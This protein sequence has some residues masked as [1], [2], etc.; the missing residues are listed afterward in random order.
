MENSNKLEIEISNGSKDLD[1]LKNLDKKQIQELN[2]IIFKPVSMK[3]LKDFTGLKKLMIA[4]SVKDFTP[5]SGCTS[6]ESL[7]LSG[8]TI[9][10]LDF[11]NTLPVKSLILENFRSNVASLHVHNLKTLENI[12]ISKVSALADLSFLEEFPQ[13]KTIE[14]FELNSKKLFDFSKLINLK[15]LHLTN[16][17]H[18]K[19]LSELKTIRELDLLRIKYFYANRKIKIDVEAEMRK[20]IEQLTGVKSIRLA[21]N[22]EEFDRTRLAGL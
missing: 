18:L 22:Q 9:D 5:V 19:D 11:I 10:N 12:R 4:G 21:I 7:Y 1:F 17:F 8:G 14:L 20:I 15:T 2:I 16:L 3:F 13:L 6:L